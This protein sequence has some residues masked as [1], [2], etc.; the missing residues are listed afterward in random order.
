MLEYNH[1]FISQAH[2]VF[3]HTEA[4]V[5]TSASVTL[6]VKD[7]TTT[8]LFQRFSSEFR[9]DSQSGDSRPKSGNPGYISG[10]SVLAGNLNT[11]DSVSAIN[12]MKDGL[13]IPG[14][15]WFYK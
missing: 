6:V 1:T 3:N 10:M 4:G 9:L 5:I 14:N 8:S 2:Y 7:I 15:C 12:Q 13:T 11:S